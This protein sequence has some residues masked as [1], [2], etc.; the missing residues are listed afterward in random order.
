M[1]T[2]RAGRRK[3]TLRYWVAVC[4]DDR[5][6]YNIRARTRKACN[7]QRDKDGRKRFGKP[8][9]VEIPYTDAFDLVCAVL[10][11]GGNHEALLGDY[12]PQD[13]PV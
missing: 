13:E 2:P 1:N 8:A 5:S 10:G 7:K 3:K 12:G 9:K 11:E 4:L 6:A